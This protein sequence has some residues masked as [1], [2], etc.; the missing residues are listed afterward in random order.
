MSSKLIEERFLKCE[1]ISHGTELD[2]SDLSLTDLPNAVLLL[3]KLR[4]LNLRNNALTALPDDF[5][6]SV[7]ELEI[8]NVSQNGITKLPD[9][10]SMLVKLQKLYVQGNAL[11]VLPVHLPATLQEAYFQHNALTTLPTTVQHLTS[12]HTLSVASNQLTTIPVEYNELPA[13]RLVDLSG[14][15]L[16]FIPEKIWRLHDKH[17]RNSFFMYLFQFVK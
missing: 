17:V 4:T 14:N 15:P 5:I 7:P 16:V 12:L 13:L 2:L 10:F 3:P 11:S 6:D 8:L 9:D 1:Q